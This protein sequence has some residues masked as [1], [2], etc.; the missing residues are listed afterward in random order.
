MINFKIS[1]SQEVSAAFRRKG[2]QINEVLTGALNEVLQQLAVKVRAKLSGEVLQTRSGKL[3]ASVR[4]E[5]AATDGKKIAGFVE[6]AS[7]DAFY[8]RFHEF[9]VPAPWSI[10]ATK[11]N[12]LRWLREDGGY[13]YAKSVTHPPLPVRSFSLSTELESRDWA[14][15][16]LQAALNEALRS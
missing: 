11:A 6:S 10:T 9:G 4:V 8:G 14:V 1:N 5:G 15:E 3:L 2:A 16:E 12:V 13:S 7:G